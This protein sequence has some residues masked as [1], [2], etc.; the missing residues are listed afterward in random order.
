M[1][2]IDYL[3]TELEKMYKRKEKRRIS[4]ASKQ[5]NKHIMKEIYKLRAEQSEFIEGMGKRKLK[6]QNEIIGCYLGPDNPK[7]LKEFQ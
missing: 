7:T 4:K 3:L 5:R 2:K 1:R 6:W